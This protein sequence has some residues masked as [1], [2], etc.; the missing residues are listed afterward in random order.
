MRLRQDRLRFGVRRFVLQLVEPDADPAQVRRW[1]YGVPW[2]VWER[3][4][5]EL[6]GG[7]GFH[8]RGDGELRRDFWH[9][10]FL[11]QLGGV[12]LA[13]ITGVKFDAADVPPMPTITGTVRCAGPIMVDHFQFLK[14]VAQAVKESDEL[15]DKLADPHIPV[16]TRIYLERNT[17]V[18]DHWK[19]PA[20]SQVYAE[21]IWGKAMTRT[22]VD[23]WSAEKAT[24]EAIG[25][26]KTIFAQWR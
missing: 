6:V 5:G 9:L 24:D 2:G 18:F 13:P 4:T 20:N 16:A 23:K 1:A 10:D 3:E 26:M 15:R 22:N 17:K 7:T 25:R 19:H 8:R 11:R 14:S 12:G 21:N